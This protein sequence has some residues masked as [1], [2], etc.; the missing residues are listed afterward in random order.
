MERVG[1]EASRVTFQETQSSPALA[2]WT[3]QLGALG[4]GTLAAPWAGG[5]WSGPQRER[6]QA[7]T[8]APE[9]RPL[10]V[11]AAMQKRPSTPT[12]ATHG[13]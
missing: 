2:S 1:W 5:G 12:D 9:R 13:V 10:K 8:R 6:A 3:Q 4:T 11:M 7:R